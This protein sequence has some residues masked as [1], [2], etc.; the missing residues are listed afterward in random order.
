MRM[1]ERGF[2]QFFAGNP[3]LKVHQIHSKKNGTL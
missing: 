3:G 2:A 1:S